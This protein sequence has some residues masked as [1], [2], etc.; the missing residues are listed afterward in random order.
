MT[1]PVPSRT[2]EGS[3]QPGGNARSGRRRLTLVELLV[4]IAIIVGLVAFL[5]PPLPSLQ[6][7]RLRQLPKDQQAAIADLNQRGVYVW[8]GNDDGEI[9]AETRRSPM[10]GKDLRALVRLPMLVDA[11]FSGDDIVDDDLKTLTS[12]TK[13]LRLSLAGTAITDEGLRHLANCRQLRYVNLSGTQI[14][15][16]GLKYLLPLKAL[17][18][19]DLDSTPLSGNTLH[20]LTE[21]PKFGRLS[22]RNCPITAEGH[23][24]LARLRQC[25]ILV[26]NDASS[27]DSSPR[28]E[29]GHGQ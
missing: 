15:G 9:V 22:V 6:V 16:T 18:V 21:L 25:G 14:T 19:L 3:P 2:T 17:M 24:A 7:S 11:E 29:R 27:P 13:L 12:Q 4:V 1:N 23:V 26:L 28:Y 8:L 10:N 20:V 5:L